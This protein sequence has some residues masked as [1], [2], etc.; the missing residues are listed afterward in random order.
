MSAA[1]KPFIKRGFTLAEV[2]ITLGIIGVV[3]AMT[4]PAI[5]QKQNQ[6][7]ATARLKKFYST[8]SQAIMLSEVDNGSVQYWDKAAII[9]NDDGTF[10]AVE[11]DKIVVVFFDKYLA[12]YL[13]I[14]SRGYLREDSRFRFYTR[15]SDGS[16]AWY[17]NGS[18]IDIVYDYNGGK[19]PNLLGYDRFS[20]LLCKGQKP[21]FAGFNLGEAKKS[22]DDA[23]QT[24]KIAPQKCT[25][26]LQYDNWEFKPDYPWPTI[27]KSTY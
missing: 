8:M 6:K 1:V 25:G 24:C 13:K 2:L 4:L 15:F 18:C 23:I 9:Y 19:K 14:S 10:N 3:A 26:L 7:E 5:V 17:G 21:A 16:M 12:K 22:R 27:K 20:F 11:N